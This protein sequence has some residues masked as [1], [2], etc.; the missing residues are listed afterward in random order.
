MVY[1][2]VCISARMSLRVL[3]KRAHKM[4]QL[5]GPSHTMDTLCS[6]SRDPDVCYAFESAAGACW[7]EKHGG[8]PG[9]CN[10]LRSRHTPPPAPEVPRATVQCPLCFGCGKPLCQT[11]CDPVDCVVLKCACRSR[12]VHPE[13]TDFFR[14]ECV[15][16]GHMFSFCPRSGPLMSVVERIQ[17]CPDSSDK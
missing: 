17:D 1:L 7:W 6:W 11:L 14:E 4:R 5:F 15:H 9:L 16:C 8:P 3:S 13:C 10:L 12:I 2:C